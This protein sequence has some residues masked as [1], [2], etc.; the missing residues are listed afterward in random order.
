MGRPGDGR[1]RMAGYL[2]AS[3]D[4]LALDLA[5]CG[6]LGLGREEVGH[7]DLTARHYPGEYEVGGMPSISG[8][9]RCRR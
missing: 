4:A 1:V 9:S 5:V 7:L 6:L 3:R 8:A 2:A